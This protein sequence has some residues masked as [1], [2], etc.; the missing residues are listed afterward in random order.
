LNWNYYC[1]DTAADQDVQDL[2]SEF[3]AFLEAEPVSARVEPVRLS[4][5]EAVIWKDDRVLHGRNGF[6]A[7]QISERFF[8]KT[9]FEMRPGT[10]KAPTDN[11]GQL[12]PN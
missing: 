7:R 5:G 8:W 3:F 2:R 10:M 11:L 1:V 4:P 12:L 9:A 6:S